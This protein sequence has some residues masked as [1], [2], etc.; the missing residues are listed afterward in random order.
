MRHLGCAFCL[1]VAGT[2]ASWNASPHPP[3]GAVQAEGI[4]TVSQ[5]KALIDGGGHIYIYD[6]ND[7]QSYTETGHVPGARW[8]PFDFKSKSDLPRSKGAKLIFYCHNPICGASH[9]AADRALALGY[10]N[11]WRM[12]AG[13]TGWM[14]AGLPVVKGPNPR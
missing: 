3:E 6:V 4:L 9:L 12:P 8:L 7:R 13:I 10:R 1:L 5:L 11:V 14:S 2:T